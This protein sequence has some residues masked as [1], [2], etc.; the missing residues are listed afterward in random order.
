MKYR[1]P[2]KKKLPV[3]MRQRSASRIA[4][5]QLNFQYLFVEGFGTSY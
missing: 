3:A 1:E 5:V 2:K 4:A